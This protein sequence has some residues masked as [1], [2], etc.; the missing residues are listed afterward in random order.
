LN[1]GI[2]RMNQYRFPVFLSLFIFLFLAHSRL[3]AQVI[4]T[5]TLVTVKADSVKKDTSRSIFNYLKYRL[6]GDGNFSWGNVNRTL[7]VARAEISYTRP[8]IS[9]STNP[10]FAFGQQNGLLAEREPYVDLFIDLYKQHKVYGFGLGTLEASNL[11]NI[12]VRRLG[13]LGVGFRLLD[14]K[15]H[16]LSLTNAIISEFTRFRLRSHVHVVR[17]SVRLK[18]KHSFF[19]DRLRLNHLTFVQPALNMPNLRWNTLISVE[20][21]LNK[22]VTVRTTFENAYESVVEAGRKNNDTRVTFGI[23]IGNQN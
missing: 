15:S 10:R 22:W 5:D 3:S 4:V 11:R 6:I 20:M 21:P 16:T 18:G 14:S 1:K 9:I 13:G 8:V 12:T 2:A 23:A 19:S 17:N 7:M